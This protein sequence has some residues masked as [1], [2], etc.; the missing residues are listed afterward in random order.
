MEK[1][2]DD[3]EK[4]TN[5]FERNTFTYNL[6]TFVISNKNIEETDNVKHKFIIQ[7]DW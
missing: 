1:W 7:C 4:H 6:H 3:D 5:K 2:K